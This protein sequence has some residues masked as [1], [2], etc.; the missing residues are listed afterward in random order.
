MGENTPKIYK[1]LK[2]CDLSLSIINLNLQ[3][4]KK[5]LDRDKKDDLVQNLRKQIDELTVEN[6]SLKSQLTEAQTNLTLA[7]TELMSVKAEYD[8]QIGLIDT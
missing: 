6:R 3:F 7:R 8:E 5:W 2:H 1:Y 4:E